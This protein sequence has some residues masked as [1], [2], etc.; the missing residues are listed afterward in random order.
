M[1]HYNFTNV[2]LVSQEICKSILALYDLWKSFDERKEMS[3]ILARMPRPSKLPQAQQQ[4]QQQN[5][6]QQM[7]HN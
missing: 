4:Q 2:A 7:Q 1:V 3:G 6:G 5:P